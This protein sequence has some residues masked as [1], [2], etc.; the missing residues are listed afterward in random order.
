MKQECSIGGANFQYKDQWHLKKNSSIN[1]YK[2]KSL[3]HV[4]LTYISPQ[5]QQFTLHI[6]FIGVFTC[7]N[8]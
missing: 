2:L 6:N 1:V 3:K 4:G 7:K 5:T 8:T